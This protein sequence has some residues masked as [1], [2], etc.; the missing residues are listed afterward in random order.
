MRSNWRLALASGVGVLL[1]IT[2]TSV[3]VLYSRVLAESG[4]RYA[5]DNNTSGILL[6]HQLFVQNHPLGPKDYQRLDELVTR[7]TNDHLGWLSNDMVRYGQSEEMAFVFNRED[8]LPLQDIPAAY[9]FF[10]EE[11]QGHSSLLEGR[12]PKEPFLSDG[13][14][15]LEAILGNETS[16]F[17][18]WELGK[19][20]FLVPFADAQEDKVA[21][22]VV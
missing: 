14:L 11:L 8:S 20:I 9:L 1:A 18:Q 7:D 17:L 6:N 16:N 19:T 2:I 13:I 5:L 12:W 21:V 15:H 4:I 3:G 10:R 22:T